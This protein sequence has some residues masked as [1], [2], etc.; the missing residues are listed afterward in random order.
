MVD[1]PEVN[2]VNREHRDRFKASPMGRSRNIPAVPEKLNQEEYALSVFGAPDVSNSVMARLDNT[3][4]LEGSSFIPFPTLNLYSRKTDPDRA[5]AIKASLPSIRYGET[6]GWDGESQSAFR[7]EGMR[8]ALID[9]FRLWGY[10]DFDNKGRLA[11]AW[12]QE[13]S[14]SEY[15]PYAEKFGGESRKAPKEIQYVALAHFDERSKEWG[16]TLSRLMGPTCRFVRELS[17]GVSQAQSADWMRG[18]GRT[19]PGV[20]RL[21]TSPGFPARFRNPGIIN[22]EMRG[23]GKASYYRLSATVAPIT[24]QEAAFIAEVWSGERGMEEGISVAI[25]AF[26]GRVSYAKNS[27]SWTRKR[28]STP[29]LS[30]ALDSRR[31]SDDRLQARGDSRRNDGGRDDSFEDDDVPF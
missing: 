11:A 8:V 4:G 21:L 1:F 7:T 17:S 30:G 18:L 31:N 25:R 14:E 22:A 29:S 20:A 15:A 13:P 26:D 16:L 12:D 24:I 23:E 27:I 2:R 10:V 3:E 5:I 28:A 9:S 19:S 6:Y